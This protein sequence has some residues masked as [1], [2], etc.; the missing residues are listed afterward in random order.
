MININ[1]FRS[2]ILSLRIQLICLV[3]HENNCNN[4]HLTSI[5]KYNKDTIIIL[6]VLCFQTTLSFY[7]I[8]IQWYKQYSL[9]L[10]PQ[11]KTKI[12]TKT[13]NWFPYMFTTIPCPGSRD[14]SPAVCCASAAHTKNMAES[15]QPVF[16]WHRSHVHVS[17]NFEVKMKEMV[18]GCCVCS[19]ERGWAENPLVYCDGH[20]CNVAV[21][22]GE[23]FFDASF[24][25][26]NVVYNRFKAILVV[27]KFL[28]TV[29]LSIWTGWN[30]LLTY[31][32]CSYPTTQLDFFK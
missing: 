23:A 5:H 17:C 3:T 4:R 1:T 8:N 20:G 26:T 18:G 16:Y 14:F 2:G 24:V 10:L 19:D 27:I 7:K 15:K 11:I 25:V 6:E 32:I 21:H 30:C 9:F 13:N 12:K 28:F 22:Q 31:Y 29:R